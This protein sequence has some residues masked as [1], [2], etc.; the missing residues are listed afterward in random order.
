MLSGCI[1]GREIGQRLGAQEICARCRATFETMPDQ[2]TAKLAE[3]CPGM[4]LMEGLL[5]S[6]GAHRRARF[7]NV[8]GGV[9]HE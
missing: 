3:I 4:V 2:C 1:G 6:A 5:Q 7:A 9:S 8:S